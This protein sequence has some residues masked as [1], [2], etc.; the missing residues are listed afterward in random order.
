MDMYNTKKSA[1]IYADS[2][3]G[4]T[5]FEL[6]TSYLNKAHHTSML[7]NGMNMTL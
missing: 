7:K 2:H 1:A 3:C 6:R 5:R 4:R